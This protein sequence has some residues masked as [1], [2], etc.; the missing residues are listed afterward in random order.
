MVFFQRSTQKPS[1]ILK[2]KKNLT[3]LFSC[4]NLFLDDM[5]PDFVYLFCSSDHNL[6]TIKSKILK[7]LVILLIKTRILVTKVKKTVLSTSRT[8]LAPMDQ[9]CLTIIGLLTI[10][11]QQELDKVG[12]QL[13][14]SKIKGRWSLAYIL[15]AKTIQNLRIQS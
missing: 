8:N 4:L 5:I 7:L 6:K 9:F 15:A 14:P 12:V 3:L 10:H 11:W 2:R 1:L 13:S